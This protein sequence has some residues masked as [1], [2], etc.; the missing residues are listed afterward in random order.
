MNSDTS[1]A[2]AGRQQPSRDRKAVPT[3]DGHL[4]HQ[5]H[6]AD[7]VRLLEV[8]F[9]T[10]LSAEEVHY[11]AEPVGITELHAQQS[12]E[13]KVALVPAETVKTKTLYVGDSIN[14]INDAPAIPAPA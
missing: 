2:E 13:Q 4:L 1:T 8:N 9:V 10:G 11:L 3:S 5:L 6:A 7:I 14:D 12:P